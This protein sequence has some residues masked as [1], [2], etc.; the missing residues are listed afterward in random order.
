MTVGALEIR[1]WFREAENRGATH[2]IVATDTWDYDSYPIYVM[3]GE[4]PRDK[5]PKSMMQRTEE[6]YRISLGWEA[7]SQGRVQNWELE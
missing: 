3:P 6:C 5:E 4:N 7:Q 2:L 1:G